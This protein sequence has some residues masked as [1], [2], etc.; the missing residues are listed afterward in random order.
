MEIDQYGCYKMMN[1]TI[2]GTFV[3]DPLVSTLLFWSEKSND[4]VNIK[5]AP[6]NQVFHYLATLQDDTNNINFSVVLVR[7]EDLDEKEYKKL[8]DNCILL[9]N[10]IEHASQQHINNSFI[11]CICPPSPKFSDKL[12]LEFNEQEEKIVLALNG[13]PR[14]HALTSKTLLEK[15]YVEDYYNSYSDELGHVPYTPSLYVAL[16]TLIYRKIYALTH[17]L[18]KVIVVDCDNTLWGGICAEVGAEGV[19]ITPFYAKLQKFLIEQYVQGRL[20]CLC[21]KNNL[22]DVLQVFESNKNMLLNLKHIVAYKINWELKSKNIIELAK[23]L[24]LGLNSFVFLDDNPIECAEVKSAIPEITVLQVPNSETIPTF[25]Q[26]IWMLDVNKLTE[27]DKQRNMLYLQDQH[28]TK[29]REQVFSLKEFISNL[30]IVIDILEPNEQHVARIAQLTQRTNQFNLST[31][32]LDESSVTL[33]LKQTEY[34]C[35]VIH[36]K[37][38]FGDYGLVGVLIFKIMQN[39]LAVQTFLLSCRVLERGVEHKVIKWLGEYA[40]NHDQKINRIEFL[41]KPTV[42]NDP[43]L[44]FLEKITHGASVYKK[45]EC[46]DVGQILFSLNV[47]HAATLQF[48]LEEN[49]SKEVLIDQQKSQEGQIVNSVNGTGKHIFLDATTT[50]YKVDLIQDAIQTF[51]RKSREQAGICSEYMAPSNEYEQ[52][53]IKILENVAAINSIGIKDNFIHLGI[54]SILGVQFCYEVYKEFKI[55]LSLQDIYCHPTISDL[56]VLIYKKHREHYKLN[57]SEIKL[58]LLFG[59]HYPLSFAQFRV[60]LL[61]KIMSNKYAYN[62]T[63]GLRIIGKLNVDK[64][65][66]AIN[67]ITQYQSIL[68]SVIID[69]NEDNEYKQAIL[70]VAFSLNKEN[71]LGVATNEKIT[72]SIEQEVKTLFD[73]QKDPLIRGKL[74]TINVDEYLLLISMHHIISDEYSWDI[75]YKK[76]AELYNILDNTSVKDLDTNNLLPVQY[77]DFAVWQR[78]LLSGCFLE[79]QL[80]YWKQQLSGTSGFLN[81]PTMHRPL[82][83]SNNGIEY[84]FELDNATLKNIEQFSRSQNASL[85][86]SC[87]TILYVLLYKYTNQEDIIIGTP[88]ANRHYP[89]VQNLIG[90][91]VN[92]LPLRICVN[93]E[94][95]FNELLHSVRKVVLESYEHQD[96]LFEDLVNHLQVK[97]SLSFHPLFQVM[98]VFKELKKTDLQLDGLQVQFEPIKQN[99]SIFD[100][101]VQMEVKSNNINIKFIY[102]SDLFEEKMI[103]QIA[104]HFK[105]LF[106]QVLL[107]PECKVS[108][109]RILDYKEEQELLMQ[110]M[111]KEVGRSDFIIH[112]LFEKIVNQDPDAIAVIHRDKTLTYK[113]LNSISNRF[114]HLLR[115]QYIISSNKVDN[116]ITVAMEPCFGFIIS[117]LAILKAG[118]V[119]LPIDITYPDERIKFILKDARALAVIT[120]SRFAKKF[121]QYQIDDLRLIDFCDDNYYSLLKPMP[122]TNLINFTEPNDLAYIIYTSGSTGKPKGVMIQHSGVCNLAYA[123]EEIFCFSVHKPRVLQFSSISFDVSI[124]E[125]FTALFSGGSL[126]L[127]PTLEA[128]FSPGQLMQTCIAQNVTMAIIPPSLLNI[129]PDVELPCLQT[130]VVAGE[131]PSANVLQKWSKKV[132]QLFNA[133]GPTEITVYSS[134][135]LYNSARPATTIGRP[136]VNTQSY[137]LDPYLNLT[138]IG[139]IGEIYIGGVGL[140]SGYLNNITVTEKS[141]INWPNK[142]QLRLYKTGDLARYNWDGNI[143]YLGRK[144]QQIKLYGYRI[145]L[146]EIEV[147]LNLQPEIKQSLVMLRENSCNQ[148]QLAAYFTTLTEV[149]DEPS[150]M[151]LYKKIQISLREHLPHYMIPNRMILVD[152]FPLNDNGKID[153]KALPDPFEVKD[154]LQVYDE[155][156]VCKDPLQFILVNIWK[157]LLNLEQISIYEDF[158]ALGGNSI[159][160]MK[161]ILEIRKTFN[162]T[163]SINNIFKNLTI[164]TLSQLIRENIAN[165]LNCCPN[166]PYAAC[167]FPINKGQ[168]NNK[169]LFLVHPLLGIATPYMALSGLVDRP[170][171][172]INNPYFAQD[173]NFTTIE[174]MANFYINAISLVQNEG[175]YYI[176]GWSFG[177][178]VALEMAHQLKAQNKQVEVVLLIDSYFKSSSQIVLFDDTKLLEKLNIIKPSVEYDSLQLEI[179]G[180]LRLLEKYT[181]KKYYGRAVLLKAQNDIKVITENSVFNNLEHIIGSEIEVYS[182]PGAHQELF[183]ERNI[184]ELS[185]KLQYALDHPFISKESGSSEILHQFSAMSL[186]EEYSVIIPSELIKT[187]PL[188]P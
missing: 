138:P 108:N 169:P 31:I 148:K 162:Q 26:H 84:A 29:Y 25:L 187:L 76:L 164:E 39:K 98:L 34:S 89:G 77:V 174:S 23:E 163:L 147:S 100:L 120:Q 48:D 170:I 166:I 158:F 168:S 141:F 94:H 135:F 150:K 96:L 127:L 180:N 133:Y 113:Q 82:Q 105:N 28:R 27:E 183:E 102:A 69:N 11:V 19:Q 18:A 80:A 12:L 57:Y 2:S 37:D 153:L 103:S 85:F 184:K 110:S 101:T 107:N 173:N 137:I 139:V 106:N 24:K 112:K 44:H 49:P 128:R 88:I 149:K 123:N 121:Q 154:Q 143:E 4:Q 42:R 59:K 95:T 9:V 93:G 144:D 114:G 90:F 146:G 54:N 122:T 81:L 176:G 175:P 40:I 15:Y 86:M 155:Q 104:R 140:A 75:F 181:P 111:G 161:L 62:V 13:L 60:Y 20:I 157:K 64:L 66:M 182:I 71:L 61:H 92:T 79:K 38:R 16:G 33:L 63:T 58:A 45:A 130:L 51:L 99:T 17:D 70:E 6:Y 126:C 47:H 41:Y 151:A 50:L 1:I 14:V 97:R 145:E 83:P 165:E 188:K 56:S 55:E 172:G 8:Q 132:T 35:R 119:Y 116:V 156:Y 7:F 87:L 160:G 129:L 36:V 134:I 43:V 68:R 171:Y 109:L 186:N 30:E 74:I 159:L 22:R 124:W 136:I 53:L 10:A 52:R 32:R 115:E 72:E 78:E 65:E 178:I 117:L 179:T 152:H 177:G 91:F 46:L 67:L 125:I 73:L 142:D 21:S 118:A 131:A 167:L 185:I 3:S 5:V